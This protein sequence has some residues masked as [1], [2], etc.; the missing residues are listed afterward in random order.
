MQLADHHAFALRARF[1]A[2]RIVCTSIQ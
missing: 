1:L 2:G